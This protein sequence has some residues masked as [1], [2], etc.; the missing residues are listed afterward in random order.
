[1]HNISLLNHSRLLRIC[2]YSQHPETAKDTE[3][4][5]M[6]KSSPTCLE[7]LVHATRRLARP[8]KKWLQKRHSRKGSNASKQRIEEKTQE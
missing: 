8:F 4:E 7:P 5:D 3:G 2:I 1:M 6:D